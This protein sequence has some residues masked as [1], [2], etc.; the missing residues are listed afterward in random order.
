MNNRKLVYMW[1]GI[2]II[3]VSFI[4]VTILYLK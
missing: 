2:G 4:V 1:S 3:I